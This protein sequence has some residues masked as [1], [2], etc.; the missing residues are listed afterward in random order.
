[1]KKIKVH[2]ADGIEGELQEMG[3]TYTQARVIGAV[4]R[5]IAGNILNDRA[6]DEVVFA[7]NGKKYRLTLERA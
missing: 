6:R 4:M 2:V 3:A 5:G 1:M 7:T